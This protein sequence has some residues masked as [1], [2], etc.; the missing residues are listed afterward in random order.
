M[1][2]DAA[3]EIMGKFEETK[4]IVIGDLMLDEYIYGRAYRI[5]PEAP[6]PVVNY[7]SSSYRAGGAGNVAT[8]IAALGGNVV[9]SGVTGSDKNNK[10][11]DQILKEYG[12]DT[13]GII[14]YKMDTIVKTRVM[15]NGQHVLRIDKESPIPPPNGKF[16][17]F[18]REQI[19]NYD[20]V[21]ISDYAKGTLSDNIIT[22][23][24][25][26]CVKHEKIFVVDAKPETISKYKGAYLVTPNTK[27]ALE[28]IKISSDKID[29]FAEQELVEKAAKTISTRLGKANVL[30]TRS[31]KG[32]SLFDSLR[33]KISHIPCRAVEVSD[34]SGAGDTVLAVMALCIAQGVELD[35]ASE[36]A[37]LA[38]A[39]SVR[40]IGAKA[41]TKEELFEEIKRNS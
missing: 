37:N 28:S 15:A 40:H 7:E 31:E 34:V 26:E 21:V 30:V 19:Q 17:K 14:K 29:K 36:I 2:K 3:C 13:S 25:N 9:V 11:L 22:C 1:L 35:T 23:I 20:I 10:I 41:V 32:M 4:V 39:V 18:L 33:K 8:N 24:Y 5:S 16:L 27:E 6:V 38:A 12:I